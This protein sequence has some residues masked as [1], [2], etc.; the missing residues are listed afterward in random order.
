MHVIHVCHIFRLEVV[1]SKYFFFLFLHKTVCCG[2]SLEAPRH[3]TS[4]K[5][6]QH[7]TKVLLMCTHNISFCGA[8]RKISTITI[9]ELFTARTPTSTQSSNFVV[10]RFQPV[11]FCLVLYKGI[12]CGYPFE[13]HRLVDAIQMSTHNTCFYRIS[14]KKQQY[15]NFDAIQMSTH[16]ICFYWENKK[17]QTNT[18]TSHKH[19]LISLSLIFY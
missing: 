10:L 4:N 13:L 12:C 1:S 3:A 2:H 7:M 18:K 11:Y 17:K 19:H 15:K 9:F 16:N 6:T 5:C 8:I 14:E